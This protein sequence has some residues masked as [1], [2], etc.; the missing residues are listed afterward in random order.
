MADRVPP[1]GTA[2]PGAQ[3]CMCQIREEHRRQPLP[4]APCPGAETHWMDGHRQERRGYK[5]AGVPV[6]DTCSWPHQQDAGR[7]RDS[8]HQIKLANFLPCRTGIVIQTL[9]H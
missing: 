6:L 8:F 4:K 2:P 5:G 3:A 9:C 7:Q 1:P